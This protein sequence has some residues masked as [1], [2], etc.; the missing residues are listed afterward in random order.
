M[1]SLLL[2][3]DLEEFVCPAERKLGIPK[4][5]LFEVSREGLKNIIKILIDNNIRAT[6]FTTYEFANKNK[7]LI[8]ILVKNGNEISMHGY[9]HNTSLNKMRDEDAIIELLKAKNGI[10]KI[11]K[12]KLK[13]FRSPQMKIL[14]E[15]I[16][17]KIGIEYDSSLHPTFIPGNFQMFK[18]RK[19]H[20]RGNVTEIPVSVTPFLR[21]PFSWVWFRNIG[22][23]YTKICTKLNLIDKDYVNIYFHPWDFYN[24]NTKE[25]KGVLYISLRNAGDKTIKQLDKYIKWCKKNNLKITTI[26]EYLRI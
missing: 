21:L 22:L 2:T 19:I 6:F 16:L 8:K 20:K 15:K 24:T 12:K 17:N 14:N 11:T 3:F 23:L 18:T 4:E 25:F 13:G 1:K 10:E 9:E 7:D 5:R 26:S